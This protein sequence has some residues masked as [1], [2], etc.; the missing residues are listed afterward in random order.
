M[1]GVDNIIMELLSSEKA[2][3]QSSIF[4]MDSIQRQVYD[5]GP[6]RSLIWIC[7][8]HVT[9]GQDSIGAQLVVVGSSSSV[10]LAYGAVTKVPL[11]AAQPRT[12]RC[13]G[14]SLADR[15]QRNVAC[16]D[17]LMPSSLATSNLEFPSLAFALW[18]WPWFSRARILLVSTGT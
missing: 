15:K 1:N 5:T 10:S 8:A 6:C 13:C 17:M 14:N 2:G 7:H 3:I 12:F 11:L 9:R 18:H 16:Q 4:S